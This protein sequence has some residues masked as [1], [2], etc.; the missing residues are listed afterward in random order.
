[1]SWGVWG[2]QSGQLKWFLLS[3]RLAFKVADKKDSKFILSEE[4]AENLA[5]RGEFLYQDLNTVKPVR[6]QVCYDKET[7]QT[8]ST[9]RK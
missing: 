6:G 5:G 1:M 2:S 4:G 7:Y 8:L 3:I 9:F